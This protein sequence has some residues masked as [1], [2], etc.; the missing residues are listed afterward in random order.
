MADLARQCNF[1]DNTP[2]DRW[3]VEPMS[4]AYEGI[5]ILPDLV[6]TLQADKTL[7]ALVNTTQVPITIELGSITATGRL[8]K[9]PLKEG[10]ICTFSGEII[11]SSERP[12]DDAYK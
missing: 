1:R 4:A 12:E 6:C 7:V 8:H 10:M 9:T 3:V 2:V 11:Q 5:Q